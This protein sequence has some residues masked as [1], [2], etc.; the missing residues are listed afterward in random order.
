[1]NITGLK[2]A[3]IH[4]EEGL[5]R[6]ANKPELYQKYLMKFFDDPTFAQLGSQLGE[7]NYPEAFQSAHTL[8]GMSGNLSMTDFY[9]S[10]CLLVEALRNGKTENIDEM[11]QDLCLIYDRLKGV[12]R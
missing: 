6:F 9:R 8:K 12:I 11:Y 3:G 2:A 7:K 10:V 4:Y 1:M 5:K